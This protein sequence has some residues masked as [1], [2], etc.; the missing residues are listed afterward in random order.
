MNIEEFNHKF[1][2]RYLSIPKELRSNNSYPFLIAF[3]KFTETP[4]V[5]IYFKQPQDWLSSCY[6][7]EIPSEELYEKLMTEYNDS[8]ARNSKFKPIQIFQ[9]Y[10]D[11]LSKE[12][13]DILLIY[14]NII[15]F[16]RNYSANRQ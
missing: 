10:K 11:R 9:K 7:V 6:G 12:Q 8:L 1:I 14:N 3:E 15:K 5:P 2:D 13:R 4:V 16:S